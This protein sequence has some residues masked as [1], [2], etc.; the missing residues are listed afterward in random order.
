MKKLKYYILF[1]RFSFL[2]S[3]VYGA[4]MKNSHNLFVNVKI[5]KNVENPIC[6]IIA[7]KLFSKPFK[8][9]GKIHKLTK[10]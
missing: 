5:T 8:Q 10:L 1:E 7:N 3:K 2:T 9:F 6:F 4:I